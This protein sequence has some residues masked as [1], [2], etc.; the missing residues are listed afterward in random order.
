MKKIRFLVEKLD[1][2]FSER[3]LSISASFKFKI[4]SK[5][6]FL[7]FKNRKNLD[8]PAKILIPGLKLHFLRIFR[9]ENVKCL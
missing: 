7:Y 1:F 3:F 6:W 5:S 9:A 8:F 4:D 2:R